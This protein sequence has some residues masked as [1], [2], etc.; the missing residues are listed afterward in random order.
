[1]TLSPFEAERREFGR[2]PFG[3]R[4]RDV[5]HFVDEVQRSLRDLWT[6]RGDAREDNERLKERLA[7]Y[8]QLE[9]QLKNTLLL[10]QDSAE[11]AHEQARRESELILREAG[12]KSRD[13][14]HAAHE[15]K[16]RLEM[17]LR[18]LHGAE[19]E[20]RQ[21]L[22]ALSGAILSH[23]DDT[24]QLVAE[25]TGNLR[26]IVSAHPEASELRSSSAET[27]SELA[28]RA[29]LAAEV[30]VAEQAETRAER[31]QLDADMAAHAADRLAAEGERVAVEAA[32][33]LHER[34]K[35][36]RR[37]VGTVETLETGVAS[38]ETADAFFDAPPTFDPADF[39]NRREPAS[40]ADID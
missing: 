10:A 5:D 13:I 34:P 25:S 31:V 1:M 7:R 38:G 21:R 8:E 26:A 19:Q 15:D 14:V 22:R 20:A 17:V 40:F 32:Q 16:Q 35:R 2:A 9:E 29:A 36:F 4:R 18:D 37:G 11:K 6:E 3:Y 28:E 24:E 39:S 33:E 23:L 27:M 30:A 12:Q